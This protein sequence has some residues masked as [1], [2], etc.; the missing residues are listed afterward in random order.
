M[1]EAYFSGWFHKVDAALFVTTMHLMPGMKIKKKISLN[2]LIDFKA[3]KGIK[4]LSNGNYSAVKKQSKISGWLPFMKIFLEWSQ[5]VTEG[6][7][8]KKTS[9]SSEDED[10]IPVKK[11]GS[12]H[13]AKPNEKKNEKPDEKK[14]EKSVVVKKIS[15]ALKR[16]RP[17]K[18]TEKERGGV[19]DDLHLALALQISAMEEERRQ[20]NRI[21]ED[22]NLEEGAT[23]EVGETIETENDDISEFLVTPPIM[24]KPRQLGSKKANTGLLDTDSSFPDSPMFASTKNCAPGTN[25][26][27]SFNDSPSSPN[28][29]HTSQ[30][31]KSYQS[32]KS[33]QSS[34]LLSGEALTGRKMVKINDFTVT[35][36]P[37][38]ALM[39]I[40]NLSKK[41]EGKKKQVK[42]LKYGKPESESED[43]LDMDKVTRRR[44]ERAN[45][46]PFQVKEAM[47]KGAKIFTPV[48]LQI[49]GWNWDEESE[50]LEVS[51]SDSRFIYPMLLSSQFSWM[52]GKELQTNT[53]VTITEVKKMRGS[54]KPII[55]H[56]M[57][58]AKIQTDHTLGNPMKI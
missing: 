20:E 3:L 44:V 52:I 27:S 42:S 11:A 14:K 29:S 32:S 16:K 48:N 37:E 8:G 25:L 41:C 58:D 1:G 36:H 54:R 18:K 43:D 7:I 38:N 12:K 5:I 49:V 24:K 10:F 40:S 28:S 17:A 56:M 57:I 13:K 2:D 55:M 33:S 21:N 6:H 19:D 31:S 23:F 9:D 4:G 15:E 39:N 46:K 34:M 53:I 51:M 50:E 45:I 47:E 26:F 22:Q 35:E 30:S